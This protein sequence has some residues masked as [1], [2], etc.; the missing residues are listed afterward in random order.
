MD[1]IRVGMLGIGQRGLQHLQELWRMQDD[2]RIKICA[3]CDAWSDNLD[4]TKIRSFVAEYR[5]DS[6]RK[7]TSFETMLSEASLD[8]LYVCLPPAVHNHEVIAAAQAGIHVFVEKP[9]SLYYDEAR[10]MDAAIAASG[11]IS[12]AGFQLRYSHQN[13][14]VRDFL[15]NKRIV[16]LSSSSHAALESHSTKHTHTEEV[17]GPSNRVWTANFSWSGS[18]VVEAGIHTVDLMRYWAG[19]IDWVQ[20]TYVPRD[21]SDI[22]N[23]G[24]N[25]YACVVNLGFESGAVGTLH[26]SKLRRVF[27]GIGDQLILWDHGQLAFEQDGPAAYYYDGPYPPTEAPVPETLRHPLLSGEDFTTPAGINETFIEAIEKGDQRLLKSPFRQS[28]NSLAAVLAANASHEIGGQRIN[29]KAFAEDEAYRLHRT[30]P[31]SP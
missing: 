13:T 3:L 19:D 2:G 23:D 15:T 16:M 26:F 17:G 21:P 11:V 14:V 25:P 20:A 30:K 1:P 31:S 22:E 5:D 7:Y 12:T 29:L 18:A 4:T 8:A 24:D 6:V 10:D 28:M 9:M 27:R